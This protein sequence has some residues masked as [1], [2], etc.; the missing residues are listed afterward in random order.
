VGGAA[1]GVATVVTG[2]GCEEEVDEAPLAAAL[3]VDGC[4]VVA[5]FGCARWW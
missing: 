1:V 2:E 5:G 4:V 3:E